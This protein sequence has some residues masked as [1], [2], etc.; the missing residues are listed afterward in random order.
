MPFILL[1]IFVALVAFGWKQ[2]RE[3]GGTLL[4]LLCA[5]AGL[6][7]LCAVPAL[8]PLAWGRT[9]VELAIFTFVPAIAGI[10]VLRPLRRPG[11]TEPLPL[12][13]DPSIL[14]RVRS[15]AARLGVPLP[16]VRTLG[17]VGQMQA[18]AAVG[19]LQAPTLVVTDGIF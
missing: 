19:G 4:R 2:M 5:S 16:R 13:T 10:A 8:L 14:A 9:G 18:L 12:A 3:G 15:I 11:T 7:M 17:T 1:A 6:T